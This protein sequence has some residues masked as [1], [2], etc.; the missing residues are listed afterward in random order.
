VPD[1]TAI[2]IDLPGS[3]MPQGVTLFFDVENNNAVER[4]EPDLGAE[5]WSSL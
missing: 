2:E 3:V 4:E 5:L 1:E